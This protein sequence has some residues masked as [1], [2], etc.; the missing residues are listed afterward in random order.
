ML[1]LQGIAVTLEL[2]DLRV[3]RP[4]CPTARIVDSLRI[5]LASGLQLITE[6]NRQIPKCSDT[7]S[8]SEQQALLT[9]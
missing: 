9:L 8:S 4:C 6:P 3:Q 2:L 1:F 5:L 7:G